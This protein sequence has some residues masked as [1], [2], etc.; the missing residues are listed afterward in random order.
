VI[1]GWTN[2]TTN[3]KET[4]A[5][6][7]C[8]QT[9]RGDNPWVRLDLK[10]AYLVSVVR[11][12]IFGSSGQ[13]VAVRVGS[14][15]TNNGNDNHQCGIVP[16]IDSENRKAIWRN[17]SCS[18][19]VW[20][21]YINFDRTVTDHYLEVCE[22]AFNYDA[23]VDI[24]IESS[25]VNIEGKNL[26]VYKR[27]GLQAPIDCIAS[28]AYNINVSLTWKFGDNVVQKLSNGQ[29]PSIYQVN[30]NN[31]QQLHIT[32]TTA[33]DNG[34]YSCHASTGSTTVLSKSFTLY[35][36]GLLFCI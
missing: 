36:K 33:S 12:I 6:L 7:K 21:R 5:N 22:V 4:I 2:S 31:M 34:K 3:S 23:I 27:K 28:T 8:G 17:V 9:G 18:P 16:Y 15:L 14:S 26:S 25:S 35:F 13:N 11:V 10:K 32:A 29:K 30:K 24:R 19:P 1:D 20:G